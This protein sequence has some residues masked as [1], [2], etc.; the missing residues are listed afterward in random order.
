M[1]ALAALILVPAPPAL[2]AAPWMA[3]ISIVRGIPELADPSI[4]YT[5]NGRAVLSTRVTTH[6]D[7]FPSHGFSRMFGQLPDGRFVGRGRLALAAAPVAYGRSQFATLRVPLAKGDVTIADLAHP[8]TSLGYSFGRCCSPFDVEL[9]LYRRLTKR[10]T[11]GSGAIAASPRG[12]VAALWLE[13][14]GGRDQLLV[15]LRRPNRSFGP[16]AVIAGRGLIS[17]LSASYDAGGDLLVAYQRSDSGRGPAR[18]R[19][20]AR[21]RR[22]GRAWGAAQRLGASSGFSDISTAAAPDGRMVVAW[23][24]QDGG[25]EAN[26]PWIVRVA[27]R[28]PG[29]RRFDDAQT[30]E[31]SRGITRSAGRVAAAMAPDGTATVAWS[32]IA[33]PAGF[34]HNYPARVATAAPSRPFSAAQTLSTHAAVGDVAVGSD[35]TAIVLWATLP[36]VSDNQTTDQV[37]ASLRPAG[38]ETFAAPEEVGPAE[39]ATL[40]RV[41][42]DPVTGRPAAVWISRAEVTQRLRFSVRTG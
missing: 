32:G 7:T 39:R 24:T 13:H 6:S 27:E 22:A 9:E 31:T 21:V 20:E 33:R 11:R 15:A 10:A 36:I 34:Q 41:A 12:D 5:G 19:V 8:E 23:G 38:S 16:P 2:A 42:F 40:P 4:T 29:A 37:F 14:L 35:G 17:S 28:R 1:A 25:E 3:P 26:T 30:L 18:R